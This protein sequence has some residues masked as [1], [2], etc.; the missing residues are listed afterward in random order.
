MRQKWLAFAQ[1]EASKGNPAKNAGAAFVAW[2]KN[3][4]SLR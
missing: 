3:Q 4:R 1:D 2:A